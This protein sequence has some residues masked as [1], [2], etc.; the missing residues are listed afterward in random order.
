MDPPGIMMLESIREI[1]NIIGRTEVSIKLEE[2]AGSAQ[3]RVAVQNKNKCPVISAIKLAVPL[4][5]PFYVHAMVVT[6]IKSSKNKKQH[7]LQCK[8]SSRDDPDQPGKFRK[9]FCNS[10]DFFYY[11]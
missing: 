11:V 7:F 8:N 5:D 3:M 2:F 9:L 10:L 6:G 4:E 1:F